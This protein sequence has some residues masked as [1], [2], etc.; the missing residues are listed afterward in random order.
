M[1]AMSGK[2]KGVLALKLPA[3]ATG[4]A[5]AILGCLALVG[6]GIETEPITWTPSQSRAFHVVERTP[7]DGQY[8]IH[9]CTG[10]PVD[11]A[12][13]RLRRGEPLGF[14]YDGADRLWAIAG[15]SRFALPPH[16]DYVWHRVLTPAD[17]FG[18]NAGYAGLTVLEI[19][20]LPIEIPMI[21]LR[22]APGC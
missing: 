22:L 6:C 7:Q 3:R 5:V 16:R 8:V 11:M 4:V 1:H 9:T 15:S 10:S 13:T 18:R 12:T 19:L 2:R 14:D 17:Q 20:A 21:L